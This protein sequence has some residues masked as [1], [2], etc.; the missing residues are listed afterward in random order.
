MTVLETPG[1][2]RRETTPEGIV[3]EWD[4]PIEIDAALR[5]ERDR[6]SGQCDLAA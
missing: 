2:V 4:V 6:G 5:I 1:A 3:I